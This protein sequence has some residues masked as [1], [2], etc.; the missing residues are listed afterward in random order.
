MLLSLS[1]GAAAALVLASAVLLP[2]LDPGTATAAPLSPDDAVR[3][4]LRHDPTLAR[5]EAD[6]LA[7]QGALR[8][9]SG[10]R[11]NPHVEARVAAAYVE[12]EA[13]QPLS[14][15]GEGF[16]AAR[17]ARGERDA[18]ASDLRR[19][20][21]EAA[22]RARL[23]WAD[24]AVASGRAQ[25]AA[26]A[27]DLATH[28]REATGAR[29]DAG[30]APALDL[31]LAR[32]EA[33]HAAANHLQAQ[34]AAIQALRALAEITG[35]GPD[36]FDAGADPL[37][38]AP[39][40][41]A[42]G[43]KETTGSTPDRSDVIAA[44]RRVDAAR[45]AVARER[46]A[47]LPAV[48]LGAFYERDGDVAQV[49]PIVGVEVP[50]W[51]HNRGGVTAAR[52]ELLV[53]ERAAE[54]TRARAETERLTSERRYATLDATSAA[55]GD[56]LGAEASAALSSIEAGYR[57]GE[58]DLL[59]TVLLRAEVVDGLGAYLDA[60]GAIAAARIDFLLTSESD[61]LIPGGAE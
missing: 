51:Q 17:S 11:H 33:A 4:A 22:A 50:L 20:R 3:A 59:Q 1:R 29:V 25:L 53:A 32:L 23:A 46:A 13:V 12:L 7:A 39:A 6:L 37:V 44:D 30:E 19:A 16:A 56:G 57:A 21:L 55:L 36:T 24:A 14:V 45:A 15:T 5:A 34:A 58:L 43:P 52:G 26:Q 28:L 38:A 8:A 31:R 48:E 60:R 49:G 40:F 61:A 10:P 35:F 18:A 54:A 42:A 9:A 2:L 27:L 41:E 47:I